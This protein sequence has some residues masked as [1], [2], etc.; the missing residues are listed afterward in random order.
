MKKYIYS[1]QHHGLVL[2]PLMDEPT[3]FEEFAIKDEYD[4]QQYRDFKRLYEQWEGEY[5]TWLSSPPIYKVRPED[6]KDFL[7][8]IDESQFEIRTVQKY[9][10]KEKYLLA[11]PN[12]VLYGAVAIPKKGNEPDNTPLDDNSI[13]VSIFHSLHQ[14]DIQKDK[15]DELLPIIIKAVEI[16]LKAQEAYFEERNTSLHLKI[17]KLT[18]L[19]HSDKDKKGNESKEQSPSV[20]QGYSEK[21]KGWV[22][23]FKDEKNYCDFLKWQRGGYSEAE[24][25]ELLRQQR[26]LCYEMWQ[27]CPEWPNDTVEE[28]TA[29]NWKFINEAPTPPL[30]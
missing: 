30:K 27:H 7:E 16:I 4:L 13:R 14:V 19:L 2:A 8:P 3:P 24:V 1:P 12:Q 18:Q 29:R 5:N 10:Y 15:R 6:I 22:A 21:Y 9:G 17:I 25:V 11:I 23:I 20:E 26:E 28:R